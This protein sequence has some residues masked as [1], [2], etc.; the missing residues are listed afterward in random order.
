M[1]SRTSTYSDFE[2]GFP[3]DAV[4]FSS[5]HHDGE[6]RSN[7]REAEPTDVLSLE[8]R[9]TTYPV[10]PLNTICSLLKPPRLVENTAK[11][12]LNGHHL[13]R[14]LDLIRFGHFLRSMSAVIMI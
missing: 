3:A 7:T 6:S 8:S 12:G 2:E 11:S 14:E 5:N 1:S 9:S 10:A 13:L 4:L